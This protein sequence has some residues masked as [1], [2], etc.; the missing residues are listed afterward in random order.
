MPIVSGLGDYL[1]KERC[2]RK[3][4]Y[5]FIVFVDHRAIQMIKEGMEDCNS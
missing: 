2:E 3:H 5:V 4:T 1:L